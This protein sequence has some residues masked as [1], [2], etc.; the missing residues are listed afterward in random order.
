MNAGASI[1][2]AIVDDQAM[3][4]TGFRM[5]LEAEDDLVVVDE[6]ANGQEAVAMAERSRPDVVL[7]DVRMPV[8]DGIEATRLIRERSGSGSGPAVLMLTTFDLDDHVHAAL[9]A[10]AAGFLLK[11]A[12]PEDLV[13]AA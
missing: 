12:T 4:R 1:R 3:V 7:M 5:I 9:R 2:V 6:A 10:G 11:D 8:M 13:H